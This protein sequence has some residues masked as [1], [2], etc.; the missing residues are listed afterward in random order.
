MMIPDEKLEYYG[1][2]YLLSRE[3]RL[4]SFIVLNPSLRLWEIR[5]F[6]EQQEPFYKYLQ[7]KRGK[8]NMRDFC[9]RR[10][11]LPLMARI[12]RTVRRWFA[13][14]KQHA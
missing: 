4:A 3:G 11:P 10:H 1:T 12:R 7:R 9:I 8:I 2:S 14:G 6:E 5:R 13:K